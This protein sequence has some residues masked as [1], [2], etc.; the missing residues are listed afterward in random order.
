MKFAIFTKSDKDVSKEVEQLLAK[1]KKYNFTEDENNPDLVFV[2]G[3]DGTFLK[4][5]HHYLDK[6]ETIKFIG[7]KLGS[8]GFFYDFSK[9][10]IAEVVKNIAKG[11]QTNK[12]LPCISSK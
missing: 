4:A 9:E 6:L 8:L 7:F 2:L 12:P 11:E 1:C 3:G 10:D 5:V